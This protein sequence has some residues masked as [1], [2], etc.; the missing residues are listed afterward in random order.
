MPHLFCMAMDC[1]GVSSMAL[2]SSGL[3]KVTPASVISARCSSDTI[4]KPPESVSM[5]LG[6]GE[7]GRGGQ[8]HTWAVGLANRR[9]QRRASGAAV[10]GRSLVLRQ[11]SV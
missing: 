1:S 6:E 3:W 8:Q 11:A 7:G 4:W 10:L 2:P 5:P 9:R